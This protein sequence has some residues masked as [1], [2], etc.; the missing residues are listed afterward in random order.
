M[1]WID[2][3]SASEVNKGEW[4]VLELGDMDVAIFNIDPCSNCHP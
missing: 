1:G 2:A 3:F 4:R